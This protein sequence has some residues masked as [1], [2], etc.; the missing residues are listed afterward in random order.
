MVILQCLHITI[1]ALKKLEF[2]KI[3]HLQDNCYKQI[4]LNQIDYKNHVSLQMATDSFG[5]LSRCLCEIPSK[6]CYILNWPITSELAY[7]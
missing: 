7:K 2:K 6:L 3:P 5:L 1:L 4:C